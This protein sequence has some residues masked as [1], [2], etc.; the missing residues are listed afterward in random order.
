MTGKPGR[1]LFCS[2]L[3]TNWRLQH[4]GFRHLVG[5]ICPPSGHDHGN[6]CLKTKNSITV[7]LQRS[8]YL[9]CSLVKDPDDLVAGQFQRAQMTYQNKVIFRTSN[10]DHLLIPLS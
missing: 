8:H 10:F 7:R 3:G 1:K 4:I 6:S 9:H 5:F 2:S